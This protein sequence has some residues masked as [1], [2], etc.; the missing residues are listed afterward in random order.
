MYVPAKFRLDDDEAWQVVRD[1]GAG[2][3]VLGAPAGL[4]SV[5]VPV[6]VADDRR[7]IT[8]HVAKA[9]SWWRSVQPGAEV[10][11]IFLAASAYVSPS[12]YP[13]R[14]DDP[15]VV[16]T[17]N[18]VAVEVR[19]RVTLHEDPAWKLAQ[20]RS[21][22]GRFERGRSPEWSV[23]DAPAGYIEKE[24]RAIVGLEIEVASIEGKTKLSQNRSDEDYDSVRTNLSKG[25]LTERNVAE[26]MNS[27]E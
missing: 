3:L 16:P 5:F 17:W 14:L 22:T 27:D 2:L 11:A 24:L 7:T 10:L 4:T 13:S 1:A 25:T 20:V 21:Q 18:Y 12:Y 23:D 26:R 19:G 6:V 9:N 8:S 15:R